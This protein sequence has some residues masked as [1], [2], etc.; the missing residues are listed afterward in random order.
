MNFMLDP[1]PV[2]SGA[3]LFIIR[4][5]QKSHQHHNLAFIF[6]IIDGALFGAQVVNQHA[7]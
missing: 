7:S 4:A 3:S 2:S 6:L 1:K 5:G